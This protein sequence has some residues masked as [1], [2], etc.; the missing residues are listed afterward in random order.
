MEF[1]VIVLGGGAAGLNAAL[2]LAQARR[3]VL[4]LDDG[5][6][7]NAPAAHLHGYLGFDG[8]SP[9]ELLA[10]GRDEVRRLFAAWSAPRAPHVYHD[11]LASVVVQRD[12]RAVDGLA[13]HLPGGLPLRF[14]QGG[15]DAVPGHIAGGRAA[16]RLSGAAGE[17]GGEQAA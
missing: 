5:T 16:L 3:S 13:G 8:R 2:V 14:R 7:R 12:R 15:D 11:R 10:T 6:P 9:A 17:P 4:V 1:D